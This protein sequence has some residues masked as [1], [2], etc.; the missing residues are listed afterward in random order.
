MAG[1]FVGFGIHGH[2]LYAHFSSGSHDTT[3][4]FAT[5]GDQY[6]FKHISLLGL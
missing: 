3:S 4:D 1:F 2:S 6:F 5:V